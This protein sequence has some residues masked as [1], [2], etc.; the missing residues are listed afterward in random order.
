LSHVF[1]AKNRGGVPHG[2]YFHKKEAKLYRNRGILTEGGGRDQKLSNKLGSHTRKGKQI[3][4]HQATN[5]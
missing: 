3:T 2:E 1:Y 5:K 4:V